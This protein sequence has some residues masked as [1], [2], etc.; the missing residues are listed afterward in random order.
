MVELTASY[1]PVLNQLRNFIAKLDILQGFSFLVTNNHQVQGQVF[2]KPI[3]GQGSKLVLTESRHICLE[4]DVVP[5]DI[6]MRQNNLFIITG[7]NMGTLARCPR[8]RPFHPQ[9]E[10]KQQQ[11]QQQRQ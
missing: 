7:P 4:G 9:F 11:Q 6:D 3:V 1:I 5:N 10:G 2:S 8:T